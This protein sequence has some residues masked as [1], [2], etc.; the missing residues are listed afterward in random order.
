MELTLLWS[1]PLPKSLPHWF[2]PTPHLAG[3][4]AS[5][6]DVSGTTKAKIGVVQSIGATKQ[7]VAQ[8]QIA[9]SFQ[10]KTPSVSQPIKATL[11][12]H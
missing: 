6:L 10:T 2:E 7:I 12:Q 9:A 3:I 4:C 8:V 1:K 5:T 11:R